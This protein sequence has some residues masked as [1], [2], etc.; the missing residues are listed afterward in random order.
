MLC[1]DS[2]TS[3]CVWSKSVLMT[4]HPVQNTLSVRNVDD[5]NFSYMAE[6]PVCSLITF[7]SLFLFLLPIKTWKVILNCLQE[8]LTVGI[9]RK[10]SLVSSA[11]NARKRCPQLDDWSSWKLFLL[12][13]NLCFFNLF[14]FNLFCFVCLS[15]SASNSAVSIC[16]IR[17]TCVRLEADFFILRSLYLSVYWI[18]F[19]S[20]G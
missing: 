9:F 5:T 1:F 12:W 2:W 20:I 6:T 3:R 17:V 16:I 10:S 11:L 13:V 4:S 18:L 8:W 7:S 19:Q 14:I 15:K